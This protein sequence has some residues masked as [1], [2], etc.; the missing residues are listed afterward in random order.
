M[1]N[2]DIVTNHRYENNLKKIIINDFQQEFQYFKIFNWQ[3]LIITSLPYLN[4]FEFKF[5]CSLLENLIDSRRD[6]DD[7]Y[8]YVEHVQF[9][10]IIVN[11]INL[12]HLNISFKGKIDIIS[13]LLEILKQS[14]Q[15]SSLTI[16]SFILPILFNDDELCKYLN[17]IIKKL[18]IYK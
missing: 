8:L 17:R 5:I 11:L 2:N 16:D 13:V 6:S 14:P 9:L 10:K 4:N 1:N 18:D 7:S 15:H 3:N 12:K